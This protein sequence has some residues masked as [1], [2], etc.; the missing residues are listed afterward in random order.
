MSS[1]TYVVRWLHG[2]ALGSGRVWC[3]F[4]SWL[5]ASCFTIRGWR[6][7]R[8]RWRRR[9]SRWR[10]LCWM[11]RT[12]CMGWRWLPITW[13][14]WW[15]SMLTLPIPCTLSAARFWRTILTSMAAPLLSNLSSMGRRGGI[16]R[17][18]L[19]MRV[20]RYKPNRRVAM[21]MSIT[22]WIGISLPSCSID[23]AG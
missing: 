16:S 6:C 12:R 7:V 4:L 21:N 8:R 15:N 9:R 2:S 19:T 23:L 3:F 13:N 11:W 22:I 17:F 20:T 5:L 14:G 18:T 1:L 10:A